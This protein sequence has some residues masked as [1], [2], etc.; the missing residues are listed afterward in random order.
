MRLVECFFDQL[1]LLALILCVTKG[2]HEYEDGSQ[3]PEADAKAGALAEVLGHAKAGEQCDDEVQNRDDHQD[4]PPA[5][6]SAN[7]KPDDD[8]VDWDEE[9]PARLSGLGEDF[10]DGADHQGDDGQGDQRGDGSEL[11]LGVVF[12]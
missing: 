11:P 6:L 7:T 3:E 4:E 9:R 2:E 12:E 5:W 1:A 8:V 10:P